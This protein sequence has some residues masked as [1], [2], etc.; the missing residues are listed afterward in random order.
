[1]KYTEKIS[2]NLNE[3]LMKNYDAEKGYKNAAENVES[4]TLRQFFDRMASERGEFARELKTEILRF[5]EEPKDSGSFKG[6]VHRN[7]MDLKTLF[8]SNDEGAIIE[9]VI[10]GEEKSLD[11]Y[12]D[13][14]KERNLPASI[15]ALLFKQKTAIQATINSVKVHEELVS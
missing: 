5:G 9:E 2:K 12:Y 8:S 13:I 7:W 10:R 11:A 15:D 4:H 14:L 1:M 6:L 3:L